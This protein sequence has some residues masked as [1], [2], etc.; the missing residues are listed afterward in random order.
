M[1]KLF[2]FA[3]AAALT[4]ASCHKDKEDS[5]TPGEPNGTSDVKEALS[6]T[7]A[8]EKLE[9]YATEF[10]NKFKP[11]DQKNAIT[12][13]NALANLFDELDAP[14]GWDK[15]EEEE[16]DAYSKR[17]KSKKNIVASYAKNLSE[18]LSKKDYGKATE[19]DDDFFFDFDEYAGIYEAK[20]KEWVRTDSKDIVFKFKSEGKD[21]EF[22]AVKKGGNVEETFNDDGDKY[23]IGAPAGVEISLTCGGE[24]LVSTSASADY[25]TRES[26]VVNVTCT[27]A[28]LSVT[29]E[30]SINNTKI[31]DKQTVA[32]D[33]NT[34]IW[35]EASAEGNHFTDLSHYE[36]LC[37][38]D[39][40]DTE[41]KTK[42]YVSSYNVKVNIMGNIQITSDMELDDYFTNLDAFDYNREDKASVDEYCRAWN[43]SY[44]VK[45]YFS[46]TDVQQGTIKMQSVLED[47]W[48]T[49]EE[50][51]TQPVIYFENDGTSFAFEDYFN[52]DKFADTDNQVQ[53][54]FDKYEAYWN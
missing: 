20:D 46:G 16:D 17:A 7:S 14:Q 6:N 1:K 24:T 34:L 44:H 28:N 27:V 51:G 12:T 49:Y 47:S 43:N 48:Y 35:T 26:L 38:D 37:A 41:L 42:D 18:S 23:K 39:D 32:I 5:V 4:L 21:C 9:N 52:E 53:T 54:L 8:Q 30:T 36:S 3:T 29:S 22:K 13:L 19:V 11:E 40:E 10:I 2:Y 15:D 25:K 50:W 33:G 45:F 31:S